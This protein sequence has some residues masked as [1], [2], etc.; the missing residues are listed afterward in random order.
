MG[1]REAQ[2][3]Y[4]RYLRV[5]GHEDVNHALTAQYRI[6]KILEAQGQTRNAE[7]EWE[8]LETMFMGFAEAGETIPGAGRK[9]AAEGS[10]PVL[11]EHYQEFRK[12]TFTGVQEHD[13]PLLIQ[14][15]P[16]ELR[17]LAGA[18]LEY[19]KKYQDFTYSSAALYIQAAA[20]FDYAQMIWDV[21]VPNGFTPEMEGIFRE[22]LDKLRIPV[23]D[24]G[25]ALAMRLLEQAQKD[26]RWSEWQSKT[27]DL[28]NERFP[29]D[30]PAEKVEQHYTSQP[31]VEMR[32]GP[33]DIDVPGPEP[34]P[35][36]AET[37]APTATEPTAPGG[38]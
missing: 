28:L 11:W 5:Y 16:E 17:I 3:F 8:A 26:E 25:K 19:I 23:E 14:D 9:A 35:E 15:K 32:A 20:H 12:I 30:F 27:L 24:N 34:E 37:T 22:E 38:E 6:I 7:R 1:E 21:P 36:P 33:L 13:A 2:D 4:R 31:R 10:F 18:C 29:Q